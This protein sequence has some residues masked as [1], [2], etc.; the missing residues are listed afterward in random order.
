MP[1]A[2]FAHPL[3]APVYDA[4]DGDRDDLAA[5]LAIT[6]ELTPKL[7][8]DIGCGTGS[9]AILLAQRGYG[10]VG[11]DPAAASLEVAKSKDQ[12]RRVRWIHGDATALPAF[13]AELATMTG[14]VAQVFLTDTDWARTLQGIHAAL[15]PN[16]YL[17]FETRRPAHRA[18]EEWAAD[19][20]PVTLDV[21][22]IGPVE[23]RLEVTD[24]SLPLV[25]FRYTYRF[26]TDGVV[27]TSDST[28]R[29][30]SREEVESSLAANGYRVVDVREAPDRPG[31]E[32]VFV[33]QRSPA[34]SRS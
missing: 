23:R 24:V 12:G 3:L 21:P 32:F 15:R 28:L 14:N 31:R 18:W 34:V 33:A 5:Y 27:V 4:F 9:L 8:L 1:D 26:L 29:F 17:V 19:V 2:I 6:G 10:V 7:V 30:R 20:A 25:S 11:V 13:H 22:G 16:G